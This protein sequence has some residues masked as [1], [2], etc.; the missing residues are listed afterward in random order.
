MAGNSKKVVHNHQKNVYV[1][2]KIIAILSRQD[3]FGI[4]GAPSG[5]AITRSTRTVL[6]KTLRQVLMKLFWKR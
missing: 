5:P 1:K 2:F 3:M 4:I 6:S